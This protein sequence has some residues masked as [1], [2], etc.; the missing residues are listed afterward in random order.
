MLV[1]GMEVDVQAVLTGEAIGTGLV[2]TIVLE[3]VVVQLT[4][5]TE[6]GS[7]FNYQ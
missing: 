5:G 2:L 4:I 1:T 6:T 7:V 3:G